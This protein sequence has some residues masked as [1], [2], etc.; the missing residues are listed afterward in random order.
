MTKGEYDEFGG[1]HVDL[2]CE[3]ADDVRYVELAH[4]FITT[5]CYWNTKEDK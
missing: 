1:K 2:K 4:G 3:L 5:N